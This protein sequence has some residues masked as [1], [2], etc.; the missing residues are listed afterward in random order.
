MKG[1]AYQCGDFIALLFLEMAKTTPAFSTHHPI[2]Q[3]LPTWRKDPPQ[4]KRL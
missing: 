1:G 2:S 3:Q 4:A